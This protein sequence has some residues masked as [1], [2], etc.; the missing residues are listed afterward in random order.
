MKANLDNCKYCDINYTDL[1][2]FGHDSY[3]C[4]C[5]KLNKEVNYIYCSNKCTIGCKKEGD[6]YE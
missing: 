6:V 4:F 1:D 3:I 2:I 5:K